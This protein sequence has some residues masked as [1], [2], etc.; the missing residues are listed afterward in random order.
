MLTVWLARAV[1]SDT[2]PQLSVRFATS[3]PSS[4]AGQLAR[5]FSASL[6]FEP[7]SAVETATVRP[8]FAAIRPGDRVFIEPGEKLWHG[9]A[10]TR[11]T[12]HVSIQ[13]AYE[14]GNVVTEHVSDVQYAR[15]ASFTEGGN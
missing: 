3:M 1:A 5:R 8:G 7:G 14:Q 13:Q 4:V 11:L 6:D 10:V 9:A 12:T 15:A 2:V